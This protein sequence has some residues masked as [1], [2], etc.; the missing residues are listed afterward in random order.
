MTWTPRDLLLA[1][2][3]TSEEWAKCRDKLNSSGP[4]RSKMHR[5]HQLPWAWITYAQRL[6][7]TYGEAGALERLNA[8]L[9]VAA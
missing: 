3:L 6:V 9:A 7:W 1:C 4:A 5:V 2:V 8:P